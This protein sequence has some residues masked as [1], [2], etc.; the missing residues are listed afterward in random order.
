[1]KLVDDAVDDDNDAAA[2]AAAAVADAAVADAVLLPHPH[3]L[4]ERQ[5]VS[6]ASFFYFLQKERLLLYVITI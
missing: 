1:M 2:A 6:S 3:V 4:V 5:D